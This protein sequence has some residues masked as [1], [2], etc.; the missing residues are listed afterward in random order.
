MKR[1][2]FKTINGV[3]YT[4]KLNW[5]T[6]T[7]INFIN[8]LN[9][10]HYCD[11]FA[12]DGNLLDALNNFDKTPHLPIIGFDLNRPEK[13]KKNDS[14][15]KIPELPEKSIIITNPPWLGKSSA[16]KKGILNEVEAY[17]DTDGLKFVD[18]YEVAIYRMIQSGHPFVS[19][20]PDSVITSDSKRFK[21]KNKLTAIISLKES[22]FNDTGYLTSVVLYDPNNKSPL[23]IYWSK[24]T[25]HGIQDDY[26][27]TM[28]EIESKKFSMDKRLGKPKRDIRFN[29]LSGPIGVR[30][31]DMIKENDK[32]GF[33][34]AED[35]SIRP[36]KN[37]KNLRFATHVHIDPKELEG[38]DTN[39]LVDRCNE[40]LR[41]YR[42]GPCEILNPSFM[43]N[44]HLGQRRRRISS[45]LI[46]YI[47]E[48]VLDELQGKKV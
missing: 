19:L 7:V 30:L 42:A 27:G 4:T 20:V 35:F 1:D 18:L 31:L 48:I 38:I 13:W 25:D 9:P 32:A 39:V 5:L 14:L 3:F 8:S 16:S 22:P 29:V 41:E 37:V 34:T 45:D 12:G 40:V 43:E 24:E 46:R 28:D 23:K 44:N 6:P 2:K 10:S 47:L 26:L 11:P 21:V 33:F 15:L 36:I 17:Y